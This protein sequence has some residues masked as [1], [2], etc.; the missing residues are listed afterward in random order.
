MSNIR[1][2]LP[3]KLIE[4]AR[5]A[6]YA[7]RERQGA[8]EAQERVRYRAKVEAI[9][10]KKEQQLDEQS[11]GGQLE[12]VKAKSYKVWTH[13]YCVC[14]GFLLIPKAVI[15]PPSTAQ[16]PPIYSFVSQEWVRKNPSDPNDGTLVLRTLITPNTSG[17]LIRMTLAEGDF[18]ACEYAVLGDTRTPADQ[19]QHPGIW[20]GE[21]PYDAL[22]Q[23][24]PGF[25]FDPSTESLTNSAIY[26]TDRTLLTWI[27]G[28]GAEW[29]TYIDDYLGR[30]NLGFFYHVATKTPPPAKTDQGIYETYGALVP[31]RFKRDP[32]TQDN[33]NT[34]KDESI[35]A[36][37]GDVYSTC[38]FEV[39]VS[40]GTAPTP[41]T[42][43][44]I[45]EID[46]SFTYVNNP[47]FPGYTNLDNRVISHEVVHVGGSVS[48]GDYT[49]TLDPLYQKT[50]YGTVKTAEWSE[51][52]RGHLVVVIGDI[53]FSIESAN[54]PKTV[55]GFQPKEKWTIYYWSSDETI[56]DF[57]EVNPSSE[58]HLAV[59]YQKNT[60]PNPA[61]GE[62]EAT[63]TCEIF[64]NGSKAASLTRGQEVSGSKLMATAIAGLSE[65]WANRLVTD[66]STSES[67]EYATFSAFPEKGEEGRL[68]TALD[69]NKNYIWSSVQ[70]YSQKV[71][72]NLLNTKIVRRI[73]KFPSVE[74]AQ[75]AFPDT[76]DA[77][78]N[79]SFLSG[80]QTGIIV[81]VDE[82][83]NQLVGTYT[84][85]ASFI[86]PTSE[87]RV[88][89]HSLRFTPEQAL[90]SDDFTPP[91]QI[92]S[93][94]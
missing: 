11:R 9:K 61:Q 27:D 65:K 55:T 14:G 83:T 87:C 62:P 54:R 29:P 67:S 15:F 46:G 74:A 17:G 85:S 40:L 49:E 1:L 56:N 16:V 59:V 82:Y 36:F 69:I 6:Q 18:D 91:A 81:Q 39:I 7:N 86:E 79:L 75:A 60:N 26:E 3:P 72:Y 57:V 50:V 51:F 21:G 44:S 48:L 76:E 20:S 35:E 23:A 4:S 19:N 5:A 30:R 70:G 58:Y 89:F 24:A 92:T 88:G 28:Q 12:H 34:P 10:A 78:Y 77:N 37:G 22:E 8:K 73:F 53:T 68:Y 13:P 45:K 47:N 80:D 52:S 32:S 93:L 90:Y 43:S 66:I 42:N 63:Q 41:V 64:I 25:V 84:P 94:A 38:T 31:L 71:Q 33:Q 2:R